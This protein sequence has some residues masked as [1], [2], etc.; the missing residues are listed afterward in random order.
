MSAPNSGPDATDPKQE[1]ASKANQP[2]SASEWLGLAITSS[3]LL[4]VIGVVGYLWISDRQ[5]QPPI[6]GVNYT[7]VRQRNDQ[8]YVPFNVI[9]AGGK[10][11]ASVQVVAELRIDGVVVERGEQIIDFLSSQEEAQ[12]AFIFTRN[13]QEGELTIRVASYR[14]P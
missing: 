6:L 2:K 10:T 4:A 13:P 8:F 1:A 12:G 5:Q 11:A 14:R 9:N 7:E 3:V